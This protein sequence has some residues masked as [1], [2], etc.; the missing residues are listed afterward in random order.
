MKNIFF[1]RKIFHSIDKITWQAKDWSNS[2]DMATEEKTEE[3]T[4]VTLVFHSRFPSA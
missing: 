4:E 1:S 3:S 2:T